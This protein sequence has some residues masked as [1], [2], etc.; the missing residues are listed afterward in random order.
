MTRFVVQPL[1]P[2][3]AIGGASR[4]MSSR[5]VVG[6]FATCPDLSHDVATG[7]TTNRTI[8]RRCHDWSFDTSPDAIF[9]VIS[10]ARYHD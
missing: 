1:V 2:H 7:G 10:V 4:R 9:I 6:L 8:G 3:L 5:S